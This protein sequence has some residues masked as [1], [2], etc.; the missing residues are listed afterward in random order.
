MARSPNTTAGGQPFDRATIDAVW[1]K[2]TVAYG[3]NPVLRR[4]DS[5]GAFID[6]YQYGQTN[7][8]GTGWEIDHIQPIAKGGG[9]NL[10][11]LQPLQWENN[12]HKSD[13]TGHVQ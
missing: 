10:S 11:N 2:V 3:Y 1:C 5:C 8:Q 12:R 9:D 6:Y 7:P 13:R 4:L